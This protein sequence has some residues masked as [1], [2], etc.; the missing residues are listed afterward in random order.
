MPKLTDEEKK[1]KARWQRILRTYGLSKEQYEE[2]DKGHCPICLRQWSET[3]RPVVDHD[4]VA[5]LVR[6]I[7][8]RYCNHRRI[9]HHRDADLV[10]RIADYLRG[11]FT[12]KMPPKKKKKRKRKRKT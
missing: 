5:N 2:L 8:C 10:Q 11:P 7:V 4:H 9:G 12:I 6:G 3:V 1:E